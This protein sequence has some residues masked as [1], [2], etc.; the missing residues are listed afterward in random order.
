MTKASSS[1]VLLLLSL[2][3]RL[4]AALDNLFTW[5]VSAIERVRESIELNREERSSISAAVWNLYNTTGYDVAELI[6]DGF[7]S[8]TSK[9]MTVPGAK[10]DKHY[11]V[12]LVPYAFPCNDA[13]EGCVD[14][15][16]KTFTGKC[17]KD[18]FPWIICDGKV[19]TCRWLL[20]LEYCSAPPR[21]HLSTYMFLSICFNCFDFAAQPPSSR[22][23]RQTEP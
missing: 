13:P 14:Y 12:S 11:F 22:R 23:H 16:G 18:G 4:G 6:R 9:N 2:T 1:A 10:G 21:N 19:R 7:P 5:D 15:K 17:S 3:C 20:I 8:V